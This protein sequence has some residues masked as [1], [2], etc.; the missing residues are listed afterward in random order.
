MATLKEYNRYGEELERLLLLRSSPVA[1]KM[2]RTEADIPKGAWR[3]KR[4]GG[5]HLAQCQAFTMSRRQGATVAMLKEDNW[6]WAPL[7]GWGLVDQPDPADIFYAS[8][9]CF[10]RGNYI[11]IVTAPLKTASF[12][13]DMILVYSNTAQL[14][15]MLSALKTR[16]NPLV[17]SEF[18]PIDSCIYSIVPVMESGQCRITLP[19]PGEYERA[20]TGEDEIIFSV[21]ADKIEALVAGLQRTDEQKRGYVNQHPEMMPDFP[22]PPFY[23]KLFKD[24]GL[25]VE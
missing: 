21:P 4:D 22:R 6:C 15:N 1:V 5:I 10:E 13:P 7:V 14:R 24:W 18:D 25:D 8:F 19:D 3:P 11:G 2:L 17:R 23:K 16:E 9:P 20:L 12:E